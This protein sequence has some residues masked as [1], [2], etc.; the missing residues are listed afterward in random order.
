MMWPCYLGPVCGAASWV[1]LPTSDEFQMPEAARSLY[2]YY[3]VPLQHSVHAKVLIETMQ[4]QLRAAYPGLRAQL[5]SRL[6]HAI[7]ASEATWMEVYEHPQGLSVACEQSLAMLVKGL[8]E[9]MLGS[10]HMEVFCPLAASPPG[11][12]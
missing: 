11:A 4:C 2:V 1:T 9:G 12:A 8:P 3:R 5:M 7:D 10:R 6:D